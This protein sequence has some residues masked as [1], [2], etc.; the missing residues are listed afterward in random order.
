[1]QEYG[2]KATFR[3]IAHV[4]RK[5]PDAIRRNHSLPLPE[6]MDPPKIRP[7]IENAIETAL[8]HFKMI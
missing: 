8:K 2:L 5:H 3:Q 1:M 4:K 7:E 6:G